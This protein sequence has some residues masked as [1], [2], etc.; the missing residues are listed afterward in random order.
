M[1][2]KPNHVLLVEDNPQDEAL[3]LRSLRKVN[4]ANTIDVL[5]YDQQALD[6]LFREGE[7]ATRAGLELPTLV[8]LDIGLPRLNGLRALQALR[9]DPRTELLPVGGADLLGRGT[10]QAAKLPQRRQPLCPQA[11]GFRRIC[12]DRGAPG[13]LLAGHQR[14]ALPLKQ[15]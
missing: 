12:R 4:L 10:R 2:T 8:L 7:F 5:R 15:T 6:F 14:T 1:T 13:H 11:G 3:T 9:S